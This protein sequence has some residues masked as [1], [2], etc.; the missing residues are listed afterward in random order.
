M[1]CTRC[2]ASE[3]DKRL[4]QCPTCRKPVCADC[5][6]TFGGKGFCSHGCGVFFFHGDGDED[7]MTDDA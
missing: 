5:L 6:Y 1:E 2:S 4:Q 7:E 3:E